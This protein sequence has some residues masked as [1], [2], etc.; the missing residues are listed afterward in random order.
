MRPHTAPVQEAYTFAKHLSRTGCRETTVCLRLKHR[1]MGSA[2]AR[3]LAHDAQESCRWSR[4]TA[5]FKHAVIGALLCAA[6]SG[7]AYAAWRVAGNYWLTALIGLVA[8]GGLLQ[9]S[10]YVWQAV[11]GR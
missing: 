11:R 6:G 4:R 10:D 5:A 8:V 2:L 9:V 3:M 1:G 7:G